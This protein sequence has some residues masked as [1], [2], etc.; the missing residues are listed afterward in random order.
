MRIV[1]RCNANLNNLMDK[2]KSNIVLDLHT[3]TDTHSA[4]LECI[5]LEIGAAD[6]RLGEAKRKMCF[7]SISSFPIV[8]FCFFFFFAH[9]YMY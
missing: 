4:E 7:G 6:V 9:N 8:V 1:N 3:V 2:C 5:H